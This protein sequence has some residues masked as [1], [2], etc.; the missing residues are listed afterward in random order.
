MN[1]SSQILF[2]D[3]DHVCRAAILKKNYMWLLPFYM[4]VATYFYY[5]KVRRTM[6][7]AIVSNLLKY[8]VVSLDST[9]SQEF[10]VIQSTLLGCFTVT[11][12]LY[13]HSVLVNPFPFWLWWQ[14]SLNLYRT[15]IFRFGRTV[16]TKFSWV[17][18]PCKRFKSSATD[19]LFNF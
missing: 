4:V 8:S 3:I 7:T 6:R 12:H 15:Y 9:S 18:F 1:F 16:I 14:S 13:I 17:L 10:I 2:N 19:N 11:F 5:E